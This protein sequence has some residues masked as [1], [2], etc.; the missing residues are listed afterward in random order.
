MNN[1]YIS[2]QE[3]APDQVVDNTLARRARRVAL[4]ALGSCLTLLV[5]GILLVLI[6]SAFSVDVDPRNAE[7]TARMVT[8]TMRCFFLG[9]PAVIL[10]SLMVGVWV[11]FTRRIKD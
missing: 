6:V 7:A 9:T 10:L 2:P 8:V 4:A 1:P 3:E 5:G 11:M